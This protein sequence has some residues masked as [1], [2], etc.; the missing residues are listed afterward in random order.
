MPT[1]TR[2]ITAGIGLAAASTAAAQIPTMEIAPGVNIPMVGLGTWQYNDTVAEAATTIALDLGY[3][4]IDTAIGYHNQVG[5]ARALKANSRPRDS[6]FI[7]SKIPG[8]LSYADAM[9]NLTESLVQLGVDYVDLMLVHYPATWGGKGGKEARRSEWKA[10]QDFHKQGK[11]KAIGVSHYCEQHIDELMEMEGVKPAINQVEFHV[12][13]GGTNLNV[14]DM[15]FPRKPSDQPSYRGVVYQAFS[16]LCG[17]CQTASGAP[18]KELI[19][20]PFVTSIGKKYGKSGAQVSLKW[21]VQQ[22]IPVLPKSSHKA[23]Q[24]ENMDLFDWT[25]TDEDMAALTMHATP[26]DIAGGSGDCTVA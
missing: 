15:P 11:A 20:G 18:N 22:G 9:S 2:L 13:M 21:V 7:T 5:I 25:L 16:S 17:P 4:H 14:T 24:L 19:D 8:G 3:T 23:Y 26:L 10:M 6:Y 12:G 1:F